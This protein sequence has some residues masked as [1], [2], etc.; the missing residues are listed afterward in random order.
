[1]TFLCLWT[2]ARALSL[3]LAPND[4]ITRTEKKILQAIALSQPF[5]PCFSTL[6]DLAIFVRFV[7]L[8]V[9]SVSCEFIFEPI[10]GLT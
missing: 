10:S 9:L 1:M 5:T 7:Y 4:F 2:R 6:L 8:F 3:S